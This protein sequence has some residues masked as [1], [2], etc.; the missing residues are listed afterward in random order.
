MSEVVRLY[1][2]KELLSNK[3]A[4][5]SEELMAI[6]EISRATLK[7][8]I[9]KLRD[10]FRVPVRYDRERGGYLLDGSADG[11]ELAGLWFSPPTT[12]CPGARA[13]RSAGKGTTEFA[14][15]CQSLFS[16]ALNLMRLKW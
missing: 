6:L 9:T 2:Y 16:W 14:G 4:Y 8:D 15:R 10:Q 5:S 1:K 7:R 12:G 13:S 11:A 3:R